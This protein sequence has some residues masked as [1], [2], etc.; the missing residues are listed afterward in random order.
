MINK[1]KSEYVDNYINYNESRL[2][3]KKP[4]Y[5][6]QY[7]SSESRPKQNNST[8]TDF[9]DTNTSDELKIESEAV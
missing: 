8:K 9:I 1:F 2:K 5:S 7:N 6:K 4:N 3:F